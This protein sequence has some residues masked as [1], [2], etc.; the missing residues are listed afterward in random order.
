MASGFTA[1]I[2]HE[3]VPASYLP[4]TA[5]TVPAIPSS[6]S[7]LGILIDMKLGASDNTRKMLKGYDDLV[8]GS[9]DMVV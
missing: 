9:D 5:S 8:L 7:P 6:R 1:I 4:P 3:S 2:Q